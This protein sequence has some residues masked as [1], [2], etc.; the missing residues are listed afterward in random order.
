L[1][2][3]FH[4]R[5][6][7][8]NE[9]SICNEILAGVAWG[10]F[11]LPCSPGTKPANLPTRRVKSRISDRA[12]LLQRFRSTTPVCGVGTVRNVGGRQGRDEMDFFVARWRTRLVTAGRGFNT[13]VYL[14]PWAALPLGAWVLVLL[15]GKLRSPV[16]APS[17]LHPRAGLA[18]CVGD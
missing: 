3:A 6:T 16:P 4:K 17:P 11:C 7:Y 15:I 2:L 10:L 13:L 9:V 5:V 1:L 18:L 14:L 12:L 8:I